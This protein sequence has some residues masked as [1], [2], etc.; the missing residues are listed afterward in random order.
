MSKKIKVIHI[1]GVVMFFGSILGHAIAGIVSASNNDPIVFNIVR[2]VIEVET[3]YLTFPGLCIFALTGIAMLIIDKR[4]ILKIKWLAI[5]SIIGVI[6]ILNAFFVLIPIGTEL[7]SVSEKLVDGSVSLEHI[8]ELKNK[9]AIF[10]ALNI[11]AC[12]ILIILAVI[13]PKFGG[14]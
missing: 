1:F 14:H 6:I 7:L 13:K 9:E 4:P 2:Q 10:G 5:H 3:H 12:I 8:H 11:F